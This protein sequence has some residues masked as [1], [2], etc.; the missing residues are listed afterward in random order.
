[1]VALFVVFIPAFFMLVLLKSTYTVVLCK[2]TEKTCG[3]SYYP[4]VYNEDNLLTLMTIN[5]MADER[6]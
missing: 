2:K 5:T 3:M 6:R 1:M 4:I